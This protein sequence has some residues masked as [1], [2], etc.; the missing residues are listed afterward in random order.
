MGGGRT[1]S[2]RDGA[3][4]ALPLALAVLV[5][6]VAFGVLAR[7][8]GLPAV[9]VLAMSALVFSGSAQFATVSVW[10]A[11]GGVAPA[12]TAASLLNVRC[13]PM[14]I[15]AAPALPGRAL[16]RLLRAQLVVDES[17]ALAQTAPGRFE[18][19]LLQGAGALVWVAWLGGTVTGVLGT[20][21]IDDPRAL[22]LD[23]AY[24][25]VFLGLLVPLLE[26]R[27][28]VVVALLGAAIALLMTP[29]LPLGLPLLAS[30]LVALLAAGS[31]RQSRPS[32]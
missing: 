8:A 20:G 18:P 26:G 6:G 31:L 15:A 11:G 7:A 32:P 25:A 10:A 12:V 13:I 22:G 19:G 1:Y 21:L 29:L 16:A 5:D 4:R 23:G 30:A 24:P 14:G 17:W 3:S 9:A 2:W 27:G 28:A